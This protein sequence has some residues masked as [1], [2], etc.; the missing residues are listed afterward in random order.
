[1]SDNA[2]QWIEDAAREIYDQPWLSGQRR[3]IVAAIIAKHFAARA[4]GEQPPERP[5]GASWRD[6]YLH[7]GQCCWITLEE[8]WDC[9]DSCKF[10][11]PRATQGEGAQG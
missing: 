4:E 1:M 2:E 6:A 10:Y 8:A 7:L 11:V 5:L 9:H 3:E